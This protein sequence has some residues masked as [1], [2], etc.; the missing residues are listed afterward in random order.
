MRSRPSP[1]W[2]PHVCYTVCI[3][4]N[5]LTHSSPLLLLLL[6]CLPPDWTACVHET[7]GLD[8]NRADDSDGVPRRLFNYSAHRIQRTAV[9]IESRRLLPHVDIRMAAPRS[10]ETSFHSSSGPPKAY[11][12]RRVC[13]R[14]CPGVACCDMQPH[15]R[16][17]PGPSNSAAVH[18]RPAVPAG[19][20][21]AG[22]VQSIRDAMI[23]IRVGSCKVANR[24]G[25][26]PHTR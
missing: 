19:G 15:S 11:G 7:H 14:R 2:Q 5:R 23:A 16:A 20:W 10:Q 6:P 9:G 26:S 3:D 17:A 13:S 24:V 8:L 1:E 21:A 12:S 22:A 25:V 4:L 18:P